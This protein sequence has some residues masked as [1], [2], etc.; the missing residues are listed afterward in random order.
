[1]CAVIVSNFQGPY[2]PVLLKS[3][4]H[5][6]GRLFHYQGFYCSGTCFRRVAIVADS[7]KEALEKA[8]SIEVRIG[9]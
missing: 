4:S 9:A 3:E 5:F 6:T 8:K 2:K 1:M 7:A